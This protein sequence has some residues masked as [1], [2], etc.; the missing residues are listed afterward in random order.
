M[1]DLPVRVVR[2]SG[3]RSP[4]AWRRAESTASWF[5]STARRDRGGLLQVPEQDRTRRGDRGVAQSFAGVT[6]DK[7]TNCSPRARLPS[8]GVMR[9]YLEAM[10]GRPDPLLA[11]RQELRTALLR[12]SSASR[13]SGHAGA[14]RGRT[15]ASSALGNTSRR[16]LR[17]QGRDAA[18][19]WTITPHRATRGRGLPRFRR[20][21]P[22]A[23]AE[24]F[25]EIARADGG[26]GSV[27]FDP[28][29]VRAASED[30]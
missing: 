2:F 9:P 20:S 27:K 25:I 4:K 28:L 19:R 18:R 23:L 8:A 21:R 14:L 11:R 29:S 15:P 10:A 13:T 1:R 30:S 6:R 3:R 24:V 22:E 7:E 26:G 16:A 5:E 17:A 12:R